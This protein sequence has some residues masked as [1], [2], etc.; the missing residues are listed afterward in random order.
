MWFVF[1]S[2]LSVKAFK[3]IDEFGIY[4]PEDRT[5]L[6]ELEPGQIAQTVEHL[7]TLGAVPVNVETQ[8]LLESKY[9]EIT[10]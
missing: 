9:L 10:A 4:N 3:L 1:D 7:V 6:L 2:S 5:A 8:N